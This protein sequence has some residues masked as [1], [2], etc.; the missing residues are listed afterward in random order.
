MATNQR[1]T[2]QLRERLREKDVSSR[3]MEER[4][5]QR[6]GE[7]LSQLQ[8]KDI[9]LER[10]NAEISRLQRSADISK[11]QDIVKVRYSST[12]SIWCMCVVAT[13]ILTHMES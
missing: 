3:E 12:L 9:E 4:H 10:K 5:R 2:T 8:Q 7:L 1:L 13:V 11:L 6:E